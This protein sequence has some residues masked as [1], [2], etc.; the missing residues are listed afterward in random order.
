MQNSDFQCR[1]AL[2]SDD[3]KSIA[4]YLHL[5]DPY[6]YPKICENPFD[7]NWVEFVGNCMKKENNIY[8]VQNLSVILHKDNI[9]G[10]LCIIPCGTKLN[11]TDGIDN[12]SK[13][14]F[15]KLTPVID[16]YFKPLIDESFSFSGYNI[17]NVCVDSGYRNIGLGHILMAHCIELYGTETIHLDVIAS[18]TPAINLYK[19]F[20][21]E[22]SNE[23]FG[24]SG[25]DTDLLCYHMIR[26]PD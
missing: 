2:L 12:I 11:F 5:T 9:I 1:K 6:I 19:R 15:H 18:N 10:V 8:N 4:K 20:G 16:G 21:F 7:T 23:Y 22:F 24:Y 17:A 13:D 3:I 26:K 14:F 25:D